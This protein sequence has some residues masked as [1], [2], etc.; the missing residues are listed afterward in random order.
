MADQPK[1][2]AAAEFK[3]TQRTED[4]RNALAISEA[5]A[6]ATRE[7]TAR[8]RALRLARDGELP[9]APP[10]RASAAK[11]KSAKA[12]KDSSAKLADWLD[13]QQ[14]SGRNS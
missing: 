3:K 12:G 11:K 4:G 9:P 6:A 7:K 13:D 14:K 10:K 8:L 1:D 2:R 5:Q